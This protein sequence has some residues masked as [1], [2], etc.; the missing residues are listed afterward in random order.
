[1]VSLTRCRNPPS[2]SFRSQRALDDTA[3]RAGETLPAV[4]CAV[5]TRTQKD[6]RGLV[7]VALSFC[8]AAVAA[9]RGRQG[10]VV[11]QSSVRRSQL[12]VC[13]LISSDG[14]VLAL[15]AM[16]PRHNTGCPRSRFWDLGEHERSHWVSRFWA[17]VP[18]TTLGAPGLDFETWE[19]TNA[20]IGFLAFGDPSPPQHW[21]PHV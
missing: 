5:W 13:R 8:G 17:S 18:A 10:S 15:F 7:E 21:V 1:M 9:S 14:Y 12:E 2:V 4:L 19:S 20:H 6:A 16:P 3:R 11:T